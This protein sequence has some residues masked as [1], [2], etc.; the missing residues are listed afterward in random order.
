M[1][2]QL[3]KDL[4]NRQFDSHKTG[5]PQCTCFCTIGN[6]TMEDLPVLVTKLKEIAGKWHLLGVQLKFSAGTLD[7]F[8][9]A[10]QA[11]PIRALQELFTHW[12]QRMDPPPTLEAL[13][14]AVGGPVIGNELLAGTLLEHRED[15][16]SVCGGNCGILHVVL[17]VLVSLMLSPTLAH[18]DYLRK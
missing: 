1:Q 11:D 7:G 12:L 13:S 2:Y 4:A 5:L 14:K 9:P 3:Q 6:L 10:I 15:F 16:P 8:P 18:S 17:L